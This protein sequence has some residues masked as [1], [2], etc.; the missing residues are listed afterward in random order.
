MTITQNDLF[1]AVGLFFVL[2]VLKNLFD[3]WFKKTNNAYVTPEQCAQHREKCAQHQV[4]VNRRLLLH[5]N[6]LKRVTFKIALKLG[7]DEKELRQFLN[8]DVDDP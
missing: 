4:D 5:I 3:G 2:Y 7:I 6:N 8:V 1:V